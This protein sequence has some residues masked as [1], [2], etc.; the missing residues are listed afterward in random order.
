M[1]HES[2]LKKNKIQN[3]QNQSG[4]SIYRVGNSSQESQ[5]GEC[6]ATSGAMFGYSGLSRLGGRN[7]KHLVGRGPGCC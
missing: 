3:G 4:Q 6:L 2:T 1:K 7:Y 5:P